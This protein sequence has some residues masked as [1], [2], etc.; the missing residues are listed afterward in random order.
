MDPE[1]LIS[2]HTALFKKPDD[3]ERA[4]EKVELKMLYSVM[5]E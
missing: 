2:Y 1:N 4:K 3:E 5:L